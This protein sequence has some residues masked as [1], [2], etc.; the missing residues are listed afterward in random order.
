MKDQ[1]AV[2]NV[3]LYSSATLSL[4]VSSS[5]VNITQKTDWPWNGDVDFDIHTDGPPV[6]LELRLRIPGWAKSWR[7]TSAPMII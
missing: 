4:K 3:H 1:G 2:V 7:V 6:G 5:T